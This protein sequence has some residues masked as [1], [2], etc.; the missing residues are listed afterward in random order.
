MYEL[1]LP[2]CEPKEED[3]NKAKKDEKEDKKKGADAIQGSTSGE[4][5]RVWVGNGAKVAPQQV[6]I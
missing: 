6:A 1:Q 3:A 5:T 2:I 4:V